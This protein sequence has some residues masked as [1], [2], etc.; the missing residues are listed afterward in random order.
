MNCRTI[1]TVL[2]VAL[3]GGV[4]G[5]SGC[6]TPRQNLTAHHATPPITLPAPGTVPTELNPVT[7]P[8]YVI[9]PPDVLVIEARVKRVNVPERLV[10]IRGLLKTNKDEDG[11]NLTA[12]RRQK[13]EEEKQQ[14]EAEKVEYTGETEPLPYNP[15]QNQFQVRPD[16]SVYLG[17]YGSVQVAGLTTNQARLAIR[18]VLARQIN[19]DAGGTKEDSVLVLVDVVQYNSKTYYV[20]TDG[21]G[22]GERVA[23]FPITGKE[24]VS[25]AIARIGGLPE[26]ASRRNIWV[27]R[28][29]PKLNDEQ[30][31]PVDWVGI[32][33]WG[34][35]STNYQLFPGD[36]V[37]VKAQRIV[38]VDRTLGKLLSPV[39][40]LL[41]VTL[42]GTQTYNQIQ[43]RGFGFGGG[44]GN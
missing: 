9:E 37:Y 6:L 23:E 21:G 26:E 18:S 13:L 22:A 43:G 35:T 20:I 1:R 19:Y 39:E 36:R 42:L 34:V 2:A 12:E 15:I 30:I 41:G 5:A 31:L 7:L 4:F 10:K 11:T 28:R 8:E 38:T 44:T 33:Q 27:A 14:L 25:T 40:R 24:F 32:T 17:A 16:G 3:A 29:T